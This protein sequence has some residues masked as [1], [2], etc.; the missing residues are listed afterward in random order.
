MKARCV[1]LRSIGT[2]KHVAHSIFRKEVGELTA[3]KLSAVVTHDCLRHTKADYH[4]SGELL[5]W[6]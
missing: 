1:G 6:L 5:H 4:F 2:C 3:F